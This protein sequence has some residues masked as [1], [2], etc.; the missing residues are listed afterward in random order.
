MGELRPRVTKI[1]KKSA[2]ADGGVRKLRV[3]AYCRVSSMHDDQ[4]TSFET[5]KKAY[6]DMITGNPEWEFAGIYADWGI[7]GTQSKKRPEFLKMV[8]DCESGKID[9][10]ICKSISRFSRNTLEAVNYI[11]KLKDAGI[12]MIFEKEGV[13]TDAVIS[14]M[15]L[16]VLAAFA[17]E[18]SRSL[19]ENVKWGKRKRAMNG[20]PPMYPPYGY[21]KH[22]EDQMVIFPEEAEIVRWIFESYEHGMPI[23]EITATLLKNG[24]PAPRI[25]DN[26]TGCW[27]DSRIWQMLVNVKY[28]GHIL[29]QK[30]YT[31]DFLTGKQVKN[32][33]QLPQNFIENHH[34]AIIPQKQFTR[35]LRILAMKSTSREI[36]EQYPYAG[37]LKCP[38]CGKLLWCRKPDQALNQFLICE[39]EGACGHFAADRTLTDAA[40]IGAY[41][42]LDMETVRQTA[43][44]GGE[45]AVQAG[46]LLKAKEQYPVVSSVEFWWLDDH[47]ERIDF[48]KH[49]T[50]ADA[51]I[52]VTWK[53]G[54][55]QT[56]P[57]GAV[58]PTQNPRHKAAL[59]KM[60]P[61][62]KIKK[63]N[64][65]QLIQLRGA[66][67][68]YG[69]RTDGESM[70]I[71]PGEAVVVKLVFD[72]YEHG[73]SINSIL[74]NLMDSGVKP[75]GFEA[76]GS[77]TWEKTR[78]TYFLQNSKYVGDYRPKKWEKKWYRQDPAE[79][80]IE[81]C[82]QDHHEAIIPRK[83][84]ERCN[85]IYRMRLRTP[86][87]SYPFGNLL[88][89]PLC[90]HV[91]KIHKLGGCRNERHLCC[92]GERA[93]RKFVI[94]LREVEQAIQR[95]YS[96]VS[97]SQL[98]EI[99]EGKMPGD[100]EQAVRFLEMKEA[101]E[102][103]EKVDY[104]WLDE[105]AEDFEFG[106][107]TLKASDI[108]ALPPE[109]RELQDDRVLKIRWRCG[110]T[111]TISTGL[112]GDWQHPAYRAEK[113]DE[114]L[115]RYPERFPALSEEARK[116][117]GVDHAGE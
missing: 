38:D 114:F 5:Q 70:K 77:M 75:P 11:R 86:Y 92:E 35:V 15:L 31:P 25:D 91:L 80:N 116:M 21:R 72:M 40:V 52:T 78:I 34:E 49:T 73:D 30:R 103:F 61:E 8:S 47:V 37:L 99:A 110:L 60:E 71:D 74:K 53:C 58:K 56:V 89:C 24:I 62:E 57:S 102:T 109:Q 3:C 105:L 90:G 20:K 13:D 50:D 14:E 23:A 18:E 101:Y 26:R 106:K 67:V 111:T 83:Q 33:G 28:A 98:R 87:Q 54:I 64:K 45:A 2:K 44:K 22:G 12:R 97:A 66:D 19:S 6:T 51:T 7:T 16:T 10:V 108:E 81:E 95:A 32:T 107:H 9:V 79:E 59:W 104:W 93:C 76:S 42:S 41:N 46:L 96:E 68:P 65:R 112:K 94:P 1:L 85:A 84:F 4:L 17:Q 39:G 113:W 100:A 29:T 69:Y 36:T 55:Q 88:R 27:E 117:R 63:G 43:L 82:I 48:G 115:L